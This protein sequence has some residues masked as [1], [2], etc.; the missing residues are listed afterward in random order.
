L[1][2]TVKFALQT[3]GVIDSDGFLS[4][5]GSLYRRACSTRNFSLNWM[6]QKWAISSQNANVFRCFSL[7]SFEFEF[8]LDSRKDGDGDE[9]ECQSYGWGALEQ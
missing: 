9:E 3:Q 1:G 4:W 8:G 2:C 6:V 7:G 5:L